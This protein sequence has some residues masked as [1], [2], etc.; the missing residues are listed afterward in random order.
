MAGRAVASA[1]ALQALALLSAEPLLRAA[2]ITA[3]RVLRIIATKAGSVARALIVVVVVGRV[4]LL[5]INQ[6]EYEFMSIERTHPAL[7]VLVVV[8]A[9]AAAHDLLRLAFEVVHELVDQRRP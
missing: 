4:V 8:T 6:Q 7:L 5:N 3:C 1:L 2:E 9:A